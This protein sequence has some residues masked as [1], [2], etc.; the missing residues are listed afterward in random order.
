MRDA[1]MV[2]RY[3]CLSVDVVGY[4]RNDDVRQAGLQEQLLELLDAA[5]HAAGLDRTRWLLQGKGD[6]QLCLIPPAEPAP[7]V[8]GEFCRRL[9]SSLRAANDGLEPGRRMRLRLA[10]DDGPARPAA[11]G[12]SG[13]AVVGVSR[14]VNCQ[15]VRQALTVTQAALAIVFSGVVYR[16]WVH[17]GL[18]GVDPRWFR[19]VRVVEKE[20]DEQAWLWLPGID[21]HALTLEPAAAAADGPAQGA[22]GQHVSVRFDAPVRN[23]NGVNVFGIRNG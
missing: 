15:A 4:G 7:R 6:E 23:N 9:D 17:S 14:L 12:F 18:S 5:A 20:V 8:V 10:I 2:D 21:P 19:A 22:G 13:R 11:N 16:D 3:L 1:A